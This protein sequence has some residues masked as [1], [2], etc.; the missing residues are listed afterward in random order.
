MARIT[1]DLRDDALTA[2]RLFCGRAGAE[3]PVFSE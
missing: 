2:Q 3:P 1:R